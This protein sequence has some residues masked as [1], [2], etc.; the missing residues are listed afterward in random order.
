M[1][2]IFSSV[3]SNI[4]IIGLIILLIILIII[5]LKLYFQGKILKESNK[6]LI[7][8]NDK[9]SNFLDEY[10]IYKHNINNKLISI[11]SYGNEKVSNLINDILENDSSQTIKNNNLYNLPSGIKGLVAE[12]LYDADYEVI[13][14]NDL[15]EDLFS[16]L[17][18]K[19][20]NSISECLGIALD[21][22]KEASKDTKNP[23]I[24][25]DLYENDE[26]I[27]IKVGNNFINDI[28]LV[29]IGNKYYSTKNNGRGLGLFSI[30]KN[31]DINEKIEIINNIYYITLEM[32]KY[33]K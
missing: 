21:N 29:E 33:V 1:E 24:I 15:K 12:K 19:K 6:R 2:K 26:S 17:P 4:L 22:A 32:K 8:F 10:K 25:I 20:F 9:Y 31:E 28:D 11:K 7:E 16:S 3:S 23:I 30:I 27:F 13:I 14:N 5:N 18:A